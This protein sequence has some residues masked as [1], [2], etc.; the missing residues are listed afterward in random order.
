MKLHSMARRYL[1]NGEGKRK[2]RVEE[3]D[4]LMNDPGDEM[5]IPG[6]RPVE[7]AG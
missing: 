6:I 1:W 3:E 7:G 5:A 2:T 4:V